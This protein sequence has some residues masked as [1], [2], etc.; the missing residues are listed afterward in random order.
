[1]AIVD[2]KPGLRCGFNKKDRNL[3]KIE[4]GKNNPNQTR[5][6]FSSALLS[7]APTPTFRG[8][9]IRGVTLHFVSKRALED[10]FDLFIQRPVFS[11]GKLT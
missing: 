4:T 8:R 1:M 6:S 9:Y 10:K 7:P 2:Y 5:S 11:S 3:E